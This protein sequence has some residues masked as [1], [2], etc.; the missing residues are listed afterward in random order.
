[1]S[2][3]IVHRAEVDGC[4]SQV[5]Q[6][7]RSLEVW[8]RF[9]CTSAAGMTATLQLHVLFYFRGMSAAR[10][11]GH[12]SSGQRHRGIDEMLMHCEPCRP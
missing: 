10:L 4:K 11:T 2:C 3:R 7:F 5:V 8:V 9:P 1:M 6:R 12:G